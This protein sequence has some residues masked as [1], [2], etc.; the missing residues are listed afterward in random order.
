MAEIQ[1]SDSM[2]HSQGRKTQVP[3]MLR[4]NSGFL[5][6]PQREPKEGQ[7]YN[8]TQ[9]ASEAFGSPAA[10]RGFSADQYYLSGAMET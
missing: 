3:G 2:I 10:E 8:W 7:F 4:E 1:L 5:S 6:L 9:Q